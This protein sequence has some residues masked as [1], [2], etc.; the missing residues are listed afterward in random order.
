MSASSRPDT[1]FASDA[2]LEALTGPRDYDKVKRDLAAAGYKGERVVLLA[3]TDFAIAATRWRRSGTTC[4][5]AAG[6]NVDY[7][8]TDWG[9]VVPRRASREP[10]ER[11]GWSIFFTFWTGSTCSTRA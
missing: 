2:G 1:P 4:C 11:G 9:T 3:A 10:P 6:M 5:A 8:S 7:V